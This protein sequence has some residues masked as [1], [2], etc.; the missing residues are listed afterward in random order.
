MKSGIAGFVV[1]TGKNLNIVDA[2]I[3]KRFNAEID[4]LSNYKTRSVLCV[5]I[6]DADQ[7]NLI[8]V[9]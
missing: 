1:T 6:K 7:K 2:Q 5:P 8:G 4:H 3:D 9:I